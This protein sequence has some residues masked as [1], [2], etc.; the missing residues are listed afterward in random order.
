MLPTVQHDAGWRRTGSSAAI[1]CDC[2][3]EIPRRS[4]RRVPASRR[5]V[6]RLATGP[7]PHLT[8]HLLGSPH[9]AVPGNPESAH[10]R[11]RVHFRTTSGRAGDNVSDHVN[12]IGR[13]WPAVMA[14]QSRRSGVCGVSQPGNA[15]TNF[16]AWGA[17]ALPQ[18]TP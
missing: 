15:A 13:R 4:P 14:R 3:T 7:R 8:A 18:M 12:L 9:R 16:N 11:D 17:S 2:S 10:R 1:A 5:L 6:D